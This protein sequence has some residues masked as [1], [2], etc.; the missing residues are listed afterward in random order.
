MAC[1]F[2]VISAGAGVAKPGRRALV[3]VV[4]GRDMRTMTDTA[5]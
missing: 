1:V 2:L 3:G 5:T 4:A